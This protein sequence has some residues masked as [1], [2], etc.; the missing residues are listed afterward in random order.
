MQTLRLQ[1]ESLSSPSLPF[2]TLFILH[3]SRLSASTM[4]SPLSV[5]VTLAFTTSAFAGVFF[6]SPTAGTRFTAGQS[7]TITW[8]EDNTPPM[9]T[10]FGLAKASIYAGNCVEQT[11]L[12]LISA[13]IDVSNPLFLTFTPD[14]SIGPNSSEYFIR[15]ESLALH[16]A[17]NPAIPA[18]AFSHV[19]ELAGMKGAFSA[20]VQSQIDGQSTAPIGGTATAAGATKAHAPNASPTPVGA[21]K[22][23]PLSVSANK[24]ANPASTPVSG[25]A[26]P[27]SVIA[28]SRKLWLRIVMGVFGAVVDAVIL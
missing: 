13:G 6:T 18:L 1:M 9:L 21:N 16:D 5:I 27:T 23:L 14:A 8:R 10:S 12:Q 24:T 20:E 3:P 4:Y 28:C 26:V 2:L 22:G 11:S 25:A 17:S 15:F 19:F 7:A